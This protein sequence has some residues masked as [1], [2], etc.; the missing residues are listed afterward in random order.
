MLQFG[1]FRSLVGTASTLSDPSKLTP[2]KDGEPELLLGAPRYLQAIIDPS[3]ISFPASYVQHQST[4][5]MATPNKPGPPPD[6]SPSTFFVIHLYTCALLLSRLLSSI[7]V[8]I[9]FLGS[10]NYAL[11]TAGGRSHNGTYEILHSL[12]SELAALNTTYHFATSDIDSK[13]GS[14]VDR[15]EALV[16]LHN[17]ALHPLSSSPKNS[18]IRSPS[19][20]TTPPSA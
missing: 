11:S 9:C 2:Y 6:Q 17:Q 16:I 13:A 20:S 19:S 15:V 4:I 1:E 14:G 3:D 18:P 8:T 10:L 7:T 12:A 5:D